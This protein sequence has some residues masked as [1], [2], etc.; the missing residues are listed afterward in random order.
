[1]NSRSGT[2]KHYNFEG[3]SSYIRLV[4]VKE[5]FKVILKLILIYCDV[6]LCDINNC[7]LIFPYHFTLIFDFVNFVLGEIQ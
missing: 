7:P 2:E 5:W 1:M 3:K 6:S 4:A